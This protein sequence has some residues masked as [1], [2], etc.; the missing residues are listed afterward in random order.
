MNRQVLMLLMRPSPGERHVLALPVV[1]FAVVSAL[2]LTVVG[3]AQSFWAWSDPEAPI[4]H[5]LAA[6]ALVLMVVPL[7]TLGGAAA[8]LSARRRDERLSTLRLLGVSPAGVV[9]ATVVESALL[10]AAGAVAG[11]LLHL[12]LVPLVGLIPFRG[13]PLGA[14]SVLVP[15]GTTAAIMAAIVALAAVSAAVGL[16]KVVISP[17]GVRTRAIA[18]KAH[19]MRAVIAVA[20]LAIAF[21]LIV[22]VPD[23]AGMLTTIVVL[24]GAFAAAFAVL[25]VLGPWVLRVQARIRLRLAKRPDQLLSA[26]TVLDAPKAA[27]RQVSGIAMTSFIAVFAGT[28]VA[29]LDVMGTGSTA[30]LQLAVD[31]RTGLIITLVASFL[32]VSASVGVNQ[33]AGILDRVD[34]HRS[35]HRLGMPMQT[36]DRARRSAIMRPLLLTTVGG[37]V[38][39]AVLISPLLGTAIVGAPVSLLTTALVIVAG[40]ALVW[41]GSRATTPILRGAFAG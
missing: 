27:W 37:A 16:R 29:L 36:V 11:L 3:G 12:L 15:V 38:C 34:L 30:D 2:V 35:L 25:N 28:A 14:G 18:G 40:V 33:A 39:A 41:L 23:A 21:A 20:V 17:L 24:T 4:Y 1:A 13:E 31:I 5:A 19:W 7:L 6:I 9:V 26:R 10:A 22:A 8:R 32:M